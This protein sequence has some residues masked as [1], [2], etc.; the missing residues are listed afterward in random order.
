[1]NESFLHYLWQF[2]QFEKTNLQT[3]DGQSICVLKIG[4]LNSDA[5]PDFSNARLQINEI[6]WAGCVEIHIKSSDW[7][8]HNHQDDK[9]YQNVILHV[10]W[11]HN[12]AILREDGSEIP[13]LELK[14]IVSQNL[15][16][17]YEQLINNQQIIPCE[18]QFKTVSELAKIQTLDKVLLHRLEQKAQI[19]FDLLKANHD[20]WEETA[21]QLLAKNFG[22]KLNAEP[23]LQ[24][25]RNL[26]L[27]T[28]QKHRNSL[29]QIEAMLYGQAGFLNSNFSDE[30]IINLQK[31]HTF[32]AAKYQLKDKAVELH[33]WKFLRT[34]PANFPT[35]RLAQFAQIV[36]NQASFFSAFVHYQD[37]KALKKSLAVSQSEYW[38]EHHS[39]EKQSKQKLKGLGKDSVDNILINTIIPLLVCYAQV[40]DNQEYIDKA[41]GLLETL[42][43]EKNHIT[44]FWE[45]LGQKTKNAF[46]SQASIALYNDFCKQ[47][48][49]LQCKIGIE[50]MK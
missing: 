34:R 38:Q 49:C 28:L 21:Y 37:I 48:K 4:F 6:E 18:E 47:K 17:K 29:M 43:A 2:Q 36:A 50:I 39:I 23:F 32:L 1:M 19:V 25:A 11:E 7:Y 3:T 12:Q 16:E 35:V 20:D 13:T 5:G 9:A 33:E 41:I 24:L 10:V 27:K 44:D 8:L 26:P 45:G 14:N 42:P 15:L 22:F 46:D 31:E 30:Y 40:F